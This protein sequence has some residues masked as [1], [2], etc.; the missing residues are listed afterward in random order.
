[1]DLL[2]S[3]TSLL[4]TC[5]QIGLGTFYEIRDVDMGIGSV[6]DEEQ[7]DDATHGL[8]QL[9]DLDYTL[10]S[11]MAM[12]GPTKS[13]A[14]KKNLPIYHTPS[15]QLTSIIIYIHTPTQPTYIF[16]P[17]EPIS[18]PIL[19]TSLIHH[20]RVHLF[21]FHHLHAIPVNYLL[22]PPISLMIFIPR[23]LHARCFTCTSIPLNTLHTHF[24]TSIKSTPSSPTCFFLSSHVH[25]V[26]CAWS[27]PSFSFFT[28]QSTLS[29]ENLLSLTLGFILSL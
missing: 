26:L 15:H 12:H 13:F 28:T 8:K 4:D 16:I 22:L 9:H 1:M 27:F 11:C 3:K 18:P 17:T 25:G 6:V 7:F 5:L 20:M 21:H 23:T 2:L 19:H 29:P 14:K 10:I 24:L